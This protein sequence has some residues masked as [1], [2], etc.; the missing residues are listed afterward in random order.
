LNAQRASFA[1]QRELLADLIRIPSIFEHEHAI[2]E[3]VAAH[4]RSL[5]C[6]PTLVPHDPVQLTAH[7]HAQRPISTREGRASIAVRLPGTGGAP[8]LAIN[9]HLDVVPTGPETSWTHPPFSGFIDEEREIIHGRGAM[10]DK[11]GVVIALS[12]LELLAQGPPLRGDVIFH[13]V[14]EDETTGNGTLLCLEQG[15]IADA[16]LIIDGTR[17]DKAIDRHAGHLQFDVRVQGS[18]ASISVAHMG[19]NAAEILAEFALELCGAVRSRNQ[20]LQPPWDRFPSPFQCVTQALRSSGQPLTVPETA[21]GT[22]WITFPPPAALDDMRALI[23]RTIRDF[24]QT[25][26]LDDRIAYVENG[27]QS[28][29]VCANAPA[30]RAAL[31]ETAARLR[32][33]PMDIGPSTGLSDMRRFN[34]FGIPCLLYGPGTGYNPHRADEHYHLND[35]PRMTAFYHAFAQRWCG[36]EATP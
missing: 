12:V 22:F 18:P 10:D 28:E 35:L 9:T 20:R 21:E 34:V 27:F 26:G 16:A 4:I 30:L 23:A 29:P 31:L 24:S 7:P 6:A 15:F 25:R 3:R 5:G 11:A 13:F 2:V 32:M 33:P 36:V 19:V 8:S 14:L 1:R 17:S